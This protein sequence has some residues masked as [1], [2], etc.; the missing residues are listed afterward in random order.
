M[1]NSKHRTIRGVIAPAEWDDDERVTGVAINTEDEDEYFIEPVGKGKILV[2]LLDEYV[3][4]TGI[5]H[6]DDGALTVT[7]KQFR[8]IDP[9]DDEVAE[10]EDVDGEET[11][12]LRDDEDFLDAD[13]DEA[14][15]VAHGWRD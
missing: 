15:D 4:L 2:S 10:D 9:M 7:V 11:G 14:R 13:D 5:V 6:D 8:Q 1:S 3:E 12:D